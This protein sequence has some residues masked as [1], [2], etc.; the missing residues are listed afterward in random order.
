MALENFKA[1]IW[2][3]AVQANLDA[4]L[5]AGALVNT[6]YEGELGRGKTIK[7]NKIGALSV[8]DYDGETPLSPETI[9]S[10][11]VDLVV[12]QAKAVAFKLDDVDAAQ[13]TPA[14]MASATAEAGRAMANEI[15]EYVIGVMGGAAFA[16]SPAAINGTTVS[17]YSILSD[18]AVRLD[19]QSV[20]MTD[21]FV[22]CSPAFAAQLALDVRLN[23]ATVA[24]DAVAASHLVGEAAGFRVYKSVHIATDTV[25]AG[26]TVGCAF[27]Q[28]VSKTEAVRSNDFFA[29]VVR[30]LAVYGAKVIRPEVFA[31]VAWS[32]D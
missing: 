19:N 10:T 15:D 29:D 24:G 16:L 14:L 2:S 3:D 18:L 4:S 22:I 12:D 28:Q 8:A 5:V 31:K 30:T 23:R 17:A 27:A 13:A 21:R 11:A 7:I 9:T 26:H 20:P 1:T 6:S 32:L 25:V